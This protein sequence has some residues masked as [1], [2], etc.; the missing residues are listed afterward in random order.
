MQRK[1]PRQYTIR[2]IPPAVDAALRARAKA[3]GKSLNEVTVD[4]LARGAGLGEEP[5]R[6]RDLRDLAGTWLEDPEFDEAIARQD[7]I[8]PALWP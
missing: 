4:A 5:V 2:S 1:P 8:D 6:Y 3:E 7:T